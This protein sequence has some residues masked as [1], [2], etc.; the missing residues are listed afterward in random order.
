MDGYKRPFRGSKI[1]VH[2]KD[3]EDKTLV[4]LYKESEYAKEN[5]TAD[6]DEGEHLKPP[7]SPN[8]KNL[9][10]DEEEAN[11]PQKSRKTTS[12]DADPSGEDIDEFIDD[13]ESIDEEDVPIKKSVKKERKKQRQ[14]EK[15]EKTAKSI[16]AKVIGSLIIIALLVFGGLWFFRPS[17]IENTLDDLNSE[18]AVADE[19]YYSPLTG[20][21][22]KNK[23][24]ATDEATCIM[25]ENSTDARP[26]S[27]L[28]AAGIVYEAVAEGGITR[29]MAIYKGDL[30]A[31]VGPI[32]SARQT[33]VHLA[34]PYNC[35]YVHVGGA[36][37]AIDTLKTAG[38]RDLDGGWVEGQ[39][40]FRVTDRWA[41]H[42]VY[43]D[44]SHLKTW[45]DNKGW[46]E[47]KFTGFKRT[48]P[49]T[50][51]EP[52]EYTA[53]TITIVMASDDS[54][55]VLWKYNQD[56]NKY[57]R[58]HVYGG[59][60]TERAKNNQQTQI[61]TDVVIAI[62]MATIARSSEPKYYD[63]TTT[64]S[65]EA[66]IFQNGIIQKATW[67]RANVKDELK[68]FDGENNEIELN[69]GRTWISI[70][71]NTSGGHVSW[72]K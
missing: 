11:V 52:E 46:R 7:K 39:Y 12:D 16:I 21:E 43:T 56:T 31:W 9:I 72:K 48:K 41:P 69:R 50:L 65:G 32:R 6:I 59:A 23:N 14:K 66:Y 1:Y 19:I 38:Y 49:D 13:S 27:G 63:H 37:N 57:S 2:K 4:N 26:Q 68:F 51:V 40:V 20:L 44:A 64:G 54:Y 15:R 22:T 30:P 45:S 60:H 34:R 67:R 10:D 33:F 35:G 3:D 25:I 55:N 5:A 29:F 8:I 36:T 62:K 71:N 24:I 42:N 28:N 58:L 18:K 17:F 70:Y 47:S 53:K 61:T